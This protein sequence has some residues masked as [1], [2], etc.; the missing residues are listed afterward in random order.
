MDEVFENRPSL[1]LKINILTSKN[2]WMNHFD[3][4]LKAKLEKRGHIVRLVDSKTELKSADISFFLS[5][6]EVVGQEL[7]LFM[8]VIYLMVRGGHQQAGKSL[9][10]EIKYL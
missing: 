2:S 10:D 7:S 8:P 5:C 6:F 1:P 4:T 9:K 3:K